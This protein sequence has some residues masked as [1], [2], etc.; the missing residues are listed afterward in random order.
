MHNTPLQAAPPAPRSH[1]QP[2]VFHSS[3]L[4]S[5]P[6]SLPVSHPSHIP[7][8][9]GPTFLQEIL[10]Q[11]PLLSKYTLPSSNKATYYF[12][13]SFIS[14]SP[15]IRLRMARRIF[16]VVTVAVVVV[17]VTVAPVHLLQCLAQFLPTSGT[18][19]KYLL[20]GVPG[21]ALRGMGGLDGVL[22]L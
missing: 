18:K 11:L 21:R 5:Q 4:L 1:S 16:L 17:V 10:S 6:A 19:N 14:D 8:F 7:T 22:N 9:L 12:C 20:N 2:A 13:T 15:S 3:I